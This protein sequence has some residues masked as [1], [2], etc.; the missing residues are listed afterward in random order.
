MLNPVFRRIALANTVTGVAENV[1][2]RQHEDG[3]GDSH[4]AKTLLLVE[5]VT[6]VF[7]PQS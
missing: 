5:S 1:E 3:K 2:R 7:E 4:H 6:L